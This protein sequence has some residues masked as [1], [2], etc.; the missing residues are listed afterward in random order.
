MIRNKAEWELLL[1]DTAKEL[2]DLSQQIAM[3]VTSAELVAKELRGCRKRER[4]SRQPGAGTAYQ[5]E[6]FRPRPV[7]GSPADV[8]VEE[9]LQ[10]V[11]MVYDAPVANVVSTTGASTRV[12]KRKQGGISERELRSLQVD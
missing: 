5:S 2:S 12:A 7:V 11:G 8:L 1:L 4:D 3:S 6:P 9:A 10:N